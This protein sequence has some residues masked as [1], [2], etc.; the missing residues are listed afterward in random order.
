MGGGNKVVIKGCERVK[1][2]AYLVSVG[3]CRRPLLMRLG[4][5]LALGGPSRTGR[6]RSK[7]LAVQL[8]NTR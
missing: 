3:A 2:A 6:S 4:H 7:D 5:D 8:A 1:R